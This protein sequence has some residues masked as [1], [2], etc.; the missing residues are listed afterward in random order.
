MKWRSK[1]DDWKQRF[2][3]LPIT[4][5]GETHWLVWYWTR[6]CCEYNHVVIGR[7]RAALTAALTTSPE[8]ER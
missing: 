7:G 3:L 2:A 6:F 8:A 5:D 4:L 1:A